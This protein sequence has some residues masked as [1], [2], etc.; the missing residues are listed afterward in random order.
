MDMN[1]GWKNRALIHLSALRQNIRT[2]RRLA[3]KSRLIAVVKANAYGHGMKVV[4]RE[5][6]SRVD[7]FAVASI[8]EGLSLRELDSELPV[9]VLSG[10][11]HPS[12]LVS[13]SASRLDPVIHSLHQVDWIK[14]HAGRPLDVWLKFNSGMN[15]LGMCHD[16]FI[17]AYRMLESSSHV[18]NIRLMSHFAIA[19]DLKDGFTRKQIREFNQVVTGLEGERSLANS[20]GI[21]RWPDACLEWVRPGLMLYGVSPL[22]DAAPNY[23]LKPVM[24]LQTKIISL[25]KLE[26][27][28]TV[29]YGRTYTATQP[30][31]IA[32]LGIGYGDG[33]FRVVPDSAYV[34]IHNQKAPIVGRISMDSMTADISNIEQARIGDA[35]I[36]WGESPS[37]G[38]VANWTGTNT[39]EVLCRLG[40]RV[41]REIRDA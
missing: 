13:C 20:A 18:A 38:Q 6:S 35:A 24:E 37:V 15:R 1:T 19:E 14:G 5:L 10:L 22:E 36:L 9:M 8:E 2:I 31:R 23:G 26:Q 21:M 25:Q 39:H 29:G 32:N 16:D 17:H 11:C 28:D 27:G 34:M 30:M 40:T 7:G 41:L 12:Q 3:P 33:Y 4:V